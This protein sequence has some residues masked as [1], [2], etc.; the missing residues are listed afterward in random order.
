V[1][2][3]SHF[4]FAWVFPL[5]A[6]CG[7]GGKGPSAP[8][9]G[10]IADADP[11]AGADA[12]PTT[13]AVADAG[14]VDDASTVSPTPV[15]TTPLEAH[16]TLGPFKNVA[17]ACKALGV[18]M[19]AKAIDCLPGGNV[20]APPPKSAIDRLMLLVL[21]EKSVADRTVAHLAIHTAAGWFVDP[22]GP[23]SFADAAM[24]K[25]FKTDVMP[26]ANAFF[27]DGA[28]PGATFGV[29]Q[30]FAEVTYVVS[31]DP[32][33]GKASK[34]KF[35]SVRGSMVVCAIGPSGAPSCLDPI[36]T[37]P[38]MGTD[39]AFP[40]EPKGVSFEPKNGVWVVDAA[41]K[42]SLLRAAGNFETHEDVAL[43][44]NYTLTFK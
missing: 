9:A 14:A 5:I 34:P 8:G 17:A 19:K 30:E 25:R 28:L 10:A 18:A 2:R 13:S 1:R 24:M 16:A 35:H 33:S 44:G 26:A 15:S 12:G 20:S 40:P 31:I 23:E 36:R 41:A 43:A 38:Q 37:D 3:I 4:D 21:R 6:A 32:S 29:R 27:D 22:D 42:L 7:G 39:G 11:G